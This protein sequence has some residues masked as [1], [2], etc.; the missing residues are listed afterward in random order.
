M[1]DTIIFD[2]D[3]TMADTEDIHT[4]MFKKALEEETG[5]EF[6]DKEIGEKAGMIYKDKLKLIFDEHGITGV[7]GEKI[8]ENAYQSYNL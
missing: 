7:D 1:I 3:G 2:F 6:T 8:A 4:F 5:R